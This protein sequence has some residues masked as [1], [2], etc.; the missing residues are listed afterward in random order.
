MHDFGKLTM[1]IETVE[2]EGQAPVRICV[3]Y[4][5][6]GVEW[7]EL[8]RS[9]P[10]FD[11][12]VALDDRNRVVSAEPDP[13]HSQIEGHRILGLS[14]A[15]IG[16]YTRGPGGTIYG[17]EWSGTG[18]HEPV[19]ARSEYP[20]LTPRQFWLAA[21]SINISK[22]QI[23]ARIDQLEDQTEAQAFRIE[24]TETVNFERT[25][26]AVDQLAALMGLPAEQLDS[27]WLWA[28]GL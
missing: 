23:L 22:D 16:D 5:A 24:L 21:A 18:L 12:Y 25:D 28:A 9:M 6:S 10:I 20:I 26:P 17:K 13:E 14:A 15:E 7:H 11:Y 19:L 8:F 3:F 1:K 2:I 27:L 4:D